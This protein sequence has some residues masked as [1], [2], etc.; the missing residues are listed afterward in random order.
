MQIESPI[1]FADAEFIAHRRAGDVIEVDIRAWDGSIVRLMFFGAVGIADYGA[2]QISDVR[3]ASEPTPFLRRV[4]ERQWITV[5]RDHGLSLCHVIDVD[6]EIA[7]EI[8]AAG[9]QVKVVSERPAE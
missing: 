4:L 3:V 9:V 1:G 8:A 5:P 2:W 6:D 7:M